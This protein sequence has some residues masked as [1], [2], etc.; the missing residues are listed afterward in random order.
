MSLNQ[1]YSYWSDGG[2]THLLRQTKY[3]GGGAVTESLSGELKNIG[4]ISLVY[5]IGNCRMHAQ[6][7]AL[8]KI[9]EQ[10]CGTGG[11]VGVS[12]MQLLHT[13]LLT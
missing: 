12:F 8:K 13:F 1:I 10:V 9:V 11:L 4:R 5:H 6:S 3:Y 7:K 2:I